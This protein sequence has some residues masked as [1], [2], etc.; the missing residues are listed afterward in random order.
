MSYRISILGLSAINL[1][2]E[3]L[4]IRVN[5]LFLSSMLTV[6]LKKGS[7]EWG[8]RELGIREL[9]IRS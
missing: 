4:I 3:L 9:G 6:C 5:L 2:P 7:G 1:K 8:I